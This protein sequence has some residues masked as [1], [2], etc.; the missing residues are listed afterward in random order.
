MKVTL[1]DTKTGETREVAGINGFQWAENNWSCDCNRAGYFGPP[2]DF[3]EGENTCDGCHRFLVTAFESEGLEQDHAH[4]TLAD[5]NS[6]YPDELLAEHG[7]LQLAPSPENITQFVPGQE[8]TPP[9]VAAEPGAVEYIT[10]HPDFDAAMLGPSVHP[11]RPTVAVYSIELLLAIIMSSEL[12]GREMAM[13]NVR[14]MMEAVNA[15]LKERAPVFVDD[16][17]FVLA[18]KKA[19]DEEGPKIIV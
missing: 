6:G 14:T 15:D 8:E 3:V 18:K 10:L 11:S 7:I 4:Y 1:L 12:V 16:H 2:E 5:F 9:A 17:E 13:L 19:S